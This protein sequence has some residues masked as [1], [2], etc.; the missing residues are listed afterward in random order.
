M[1]F[2]DKLIELRKR[3]GWSQEELAQQLGVSRQSVS[4]W[5]GAQSI[6]DI[7]RLLQLSELFGVS[8]DCLLKDEQELPSPGM[9]RDQSCV[10]VGQATPALRRVS[11]EEA[12]AFI[13]AKASTAVPMSWA[14][15]ACVISP[16]CLLVL[17]VLSAPPYALLSEGMAMGVGMVVL[18]ALVAAACAV[19]VACGNRTARFEYLIGSRLRPSTA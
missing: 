6:P 14:T 4:K 15:F 17:G 5:E 3:S 18:V 13:K 7:D 8:V 1:I 19:F 16:V 11:L 10:D 2:A 12:N 9:A